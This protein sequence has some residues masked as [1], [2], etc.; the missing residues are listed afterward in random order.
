MVGAQAVR[1][2]RAG[3]VGKA[4]V[5]LFLWIEKCRGVGREDVAQ[6][7]AC[8]RPEQHPRT[9]HQQIAEAKPPRMGCDRERRWSAAPLQPFL[10]ALEERRPALA[11]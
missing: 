10:E 8:A 5:S 4:S 2:T 1:Q 6:A 11:S 3:K 7:F 9:Q